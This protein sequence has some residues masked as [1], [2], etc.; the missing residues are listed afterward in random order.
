M[1]DTTT[2]YHNKFTL[3]LPLPTNTTT[4]N[5]SC[6]SLSLSLWQ[7]KNQKGSLVGC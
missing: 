3:V 6:L 5:A 1:S 2:G 4:Q 7:R